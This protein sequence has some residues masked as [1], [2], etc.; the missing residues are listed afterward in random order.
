M[1]SVIDL[2]GF[3]TPVSTLTGK[4]EFHLPLL[5]LDIGNYQNFDI[6]VRLN[7]F[8]ST[9][10]SSRNSQDSSLGA[11]GWELP[12]EHISVDYQS[13]V[14]VSRHRFYWVTA[15]AQ[16]PLNLSSVDVSNSTRIYECPHLPDIKVV[17]SPLN[18][19]WEIRSPHEITRRFTCVQYTI[20]WPLW[21]GL[22]KNQ[23]QQVRKPLQWYLS[24]V[25]DDKYSEVVYEYDTIES[26][27][28]PST[29]LSFTQ[30]VYLKRIS[31]ASGFFKVEF[32]MMCKIDAE[33]NS[34]DN[35]SDEYFRPQF[36]CT[37]FLNKVIVI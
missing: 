30:Q 7:Y 6:D 25:S 4:V 21:H 9:S 36:K 14:D 12:L 27:C 20:T 23:S 19:T 29:Q 28:S 26:A 22:G 16:L 13:S 8:H 2:A 33:E 3:K 15:L 35:H 5:K 34:I 37:R 17:Y 11:A 24:S 10:S 18:E 31:C 1:K 32:D